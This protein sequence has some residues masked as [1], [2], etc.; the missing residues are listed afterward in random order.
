V[1]IARI[2]HMPVD[3]GV[4]LALGTAIAVAIAWAA[5]SIGLGAW[6]TTTREI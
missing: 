5:V 1:A 4:Q 3:G 2:G 6:K